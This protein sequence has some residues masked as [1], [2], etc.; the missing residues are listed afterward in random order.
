MLQ[1]LVTWQR[2]KVN[3]LFQQM[4]KIHCPKKREKDQDLI[5]DQVSCVGV[6]NDSV[7]GNLVSQKLILIK[8]EDLCLSLVR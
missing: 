4:C 8:V 7:C 6:P 5:K 1:D 2:A 3:I